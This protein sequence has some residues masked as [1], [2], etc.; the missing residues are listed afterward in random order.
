L[1]FP[2][3]DGKRQDSSP[4]RS[5]HSSPDYLGMAAL[6]MLIK[7]MPPTICSRGLR[8]MLKLGKG[9]TALVEIVSNHSANFYVRQN[10]PTAK[11]ADGPLT[12]CEDRRDL[13]FGFV[14]LVS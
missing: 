10:S 4:C 11:V 6:P 2:Y 7:N 13:F 1:S 12:D 3:L 14:H 8:S 5:H 9:F